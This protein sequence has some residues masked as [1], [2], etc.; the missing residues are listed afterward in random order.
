MAKTF[1]MT[2]IASGVLPALSIPILVVTIFLG[3]AF[4][5]ILYRA[6]LHPL[7]HFPGPRFSAISYLHEIYWDVYK[8]GRFFHKIRD[9]HKQYGPIVR[10]N[11][12]ELHILDPSAYDSLYVEK[13]AKHPPPALAVGAGAMAGTVSSALHKKR[14]AAFNPFFSKA[15]INGR[16]GAVQNKVE[17]LCDRLTAANEKGEVVVLENAFTALVGDIVRITR[18]HRTPKSSPFSSGN[19]QG[20]CFSDRIENMCVGNVES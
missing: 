1:N 15:S 20:L 19:I 3:H 14:R 9:M 18:P 10:I 13:W 7:A 5:T 2:V 12:D 6:Y 17:K 8:R 16:I 11:P 4:F